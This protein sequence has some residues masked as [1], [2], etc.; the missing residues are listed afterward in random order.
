MK[1]KGDNRY[2]VYALVCP[3]NRLP[4]YI[5]KGTNKRMWAHTTGKDKINTNKCRYIENIR[6]LGLE[7]IVDIIQDNM[8]EDDAYKLENFCIKET[9]KLFPFIT[10][11]T[12]IRQPPSQL[13]R[14]WSKESIEKRSATVKQ[15]HKDG[16]KRPPMSQEQRTK[17]SAKLKGKL[18]RDKVEVDINVLKKLYA[19]HTK[20][21]VCMILG[22]GM[23]SLNRMLSDNGIIKGQLLS[24]LRTQEFEAYETETNH[25]F[26]SKL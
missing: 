8:L 15:K 2:Y 14:K 4:F 24:E 26:L 1:L 13:G 21:E 12:G 9:K 7:P 19:E 23:G 25:G 11:V 17:I 6:V 10:N 3:F 20:K 18:F 22:I 16:Y 5:G